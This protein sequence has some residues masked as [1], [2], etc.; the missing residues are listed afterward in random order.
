VWVGAYLKKHR[1]VPLY[2]ARDLSSTTP[3]PKPPQAQVH[4]EVQGSEQVAGLAVYSTPR[5]QEGGGTLAKYSVQVV[6]SLNTAS[7]HSMY[8]RCLD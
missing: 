7:L 8:A 3:R 6:T 5:A 2:P 1:N 4:V